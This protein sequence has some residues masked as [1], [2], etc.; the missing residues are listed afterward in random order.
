ME[1][2]YG[3]KLLKGLKD[4]RKVL[5]NIFIEIGISLCDTVEII[6]R[7]FKNKSNTVGQMKNSLKEIIDPL[8]IYVNFDENM[9]LST[10]IKPRCRESK[11]VEFRYP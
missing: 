4:F 6:F 7:E 8:R 11:Q 3:K 1:M 5:L 10:L 9:S 2:N